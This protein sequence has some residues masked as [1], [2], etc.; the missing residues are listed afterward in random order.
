[1]K[2]RLAL[3]KRRF[4]S[5]RRRLRY[6]TLEIRCVLSGQAILANDLFSLQEN[7]PQVP[8]DVLANDTFTNDYDGQRL[9]TSVSFG[10]EGGRIELA[11]DHKSIV[12]KPPADFFGTEE[13]LLPTLDVVETPESVVV[14]VD[15]PG[16]DPEKIDVS[17]HDDV[18]EIRGERAEEKKE[19]SAVSCRCERRYG[20]FHRAVRLPA[21]VDASKVDAETKHGVLT[22]TMPKRE[23]VLPKRI[24][25]KH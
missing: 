18:L 17:I 8:L 7:G 15:V 20:S 3:R 16:F 19:E 1:M 5:R 13:A 6:E 11:G 10:S 12:Y 22:V 2:P 14:K 4:N 21:P 23:E 9:I 24:K 25:V